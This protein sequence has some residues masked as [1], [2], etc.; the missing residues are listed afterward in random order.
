MAAV[1]LQTPLTR[2]YPST[3][4]LT[5]SDLVNLLGK[6]DPS[7]TSSS[8]WY[9]QQHPQQHPNSGGSK[10]TTATAPPMEEQAFE[11]FIET[12][13]EVRAMR[14]ESE[15]LLRESEEKAGEFLCFD[16]RFL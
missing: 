8:P 3:S 1:P 4:S 16:R 5:R 7:R 13:P 6:W 12:L 14:Q 15:A 10:Q 9:L 2:D 11:A